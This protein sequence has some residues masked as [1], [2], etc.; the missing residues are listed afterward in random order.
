MS[1][2]ER[3]FVALIGAGLLIFWVV[4]LVDGDWGDIGRLEVLLPLGAAACV[5]LHGAVRDDDAFTAAE[6]L[7]TGTEEGMAS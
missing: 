6:P 1:L 7:E 3:R 2:T 5:S 4:V